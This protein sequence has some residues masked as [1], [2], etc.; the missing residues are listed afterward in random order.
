MK[1]TFILAHDIA[2]Q[3]AIDYVRTA[4]AGY[5]V[6]VQPP[7]KSRDQEERYHAMIGD[8]A[9]QWRFCDRKWNAEDMKR[10][11]IDQFR[12][13]TVKDD[14]LGPVWAE[15]GAIDMAPSLDGSGVVALGAQSRRFP[16][17]LATAFI[18]WLFALG[19]EHQ[20]RWSDEA[21]AA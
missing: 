15:M 11:C 13:D 17:K 21:R 3:G 2:R 1:K 6:T 18:E 19:A 10:L 16:K 5:R 20:V 9:E 8:I 12:R 4:P 7:Q 14:D